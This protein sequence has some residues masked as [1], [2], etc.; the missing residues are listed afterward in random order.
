MCGPGFSSPPGAALAAP[1]FPSFPRPCRGRGP[2]SPDKSELFRLQLGMALHYSSPATSAWSARTDLRGLLCC[3]PLEM[4]KRPVY[5]WGGWGETENTAFIYLGVA[6]MWRRRGGALDPVLTKAS[7]LP[8]FLFLCLH[9]F[10]FPPPLYL[11]SS[12][13]ETV[14]GPSSLLVLYASFSVV[15]HSFSKPLG[16]E[17]L[18][19]TYGEV[20]LKVVKLARG[21]VSSTTSQ[22]PQSINAISANLKR[23]IYWPRKKMISC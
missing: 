7:I 10:L 9:P 2:C 20:R 19:G 21:E 13:R 12:K 14:D 18:K 8:E 23:H 15:E 16:V 5:G 6:G 17:F 11:S 1:T 22:N 3:N 4:R